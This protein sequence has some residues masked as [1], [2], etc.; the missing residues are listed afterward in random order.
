VPGSGTPE[1]SSKLS[2]PRDAKSYNPA[3]PL[4]KSE[5]FNYVVSTPPTYAEYTFPETVARM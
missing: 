3:A 4:A 2:T 5:E 1:G